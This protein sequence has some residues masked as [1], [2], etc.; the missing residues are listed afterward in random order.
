MTPLAARS[1]SKQHITMSRV[2]GQRSRQ[3]TSV[4]FV[5]TA[6]GSQTGKT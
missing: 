2:P 4:F 5:L 1:T 6:P 3:P